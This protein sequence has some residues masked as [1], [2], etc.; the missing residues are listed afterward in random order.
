MWTTFHHFRVVNRNLKH[1]NTFWR[2]DEKK[3][4]VGKR[5]QKRNRRQTRNN[6]P[7]RSAQR[8]Q[9]GRRACRRGGRC[10]VTLAPPLPLCFAFSSGLCTKS[11]KTVNTTEDVLF[12]L[13]KNASRG[14]FTSFY[15]SVVH[16]SSE[17]F[18]GI[19]SSFCFLTSFLLRERISP[20][21]I[22]RWIWLSTVR[23]WWREVSELECLPRFWRVCVYL[24]CFL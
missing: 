16:P 3:R 14:I 11:W 7:V 23:A 13:T 8:S 15:N 18:L 4:G 2:K 20:G 10:S 12:K 9:W 24:V 22:L 1:R 5:R 21:K 6:F 17:R 19:S